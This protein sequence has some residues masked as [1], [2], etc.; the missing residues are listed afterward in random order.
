MK[1]Y[2]IFILLLVAGVALV[3]CD[4]GKDQNNAENSQENA[5]TTPQD[6]T[7][8][9]PYTYLRVEDLKQLQLISIADAEAILT[10][11][12]YKGGWQTYKDP[13][14][15]EKEDYLYTSVDNRDTIFLFTDPTFGVYFVHYK[16]SKGVVPSEAKAWLTHIPENYP[17]QEKA[18]Q[19]SGLSDIPFSAAHLM[20][21]TEDVHIQC[22]TYDEYLK[23][24]NNLSSG[25]VVDVRWGSYLVPSDWPTGY[26]GGV[27]MDYTYKN[28][29]DAAELVIGFRYHE[30]V[31][32]SGP[33]MPGDE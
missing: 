33:V 7:E 24:L 14:G 9:N 19:I 28:N 20:G 17:L 10:K 31:D 2:F 32:E 21:P 8:T 11:M 29:R 30:H 15:H 25:M 13:D 22:S 27:S 5:Q 1:K 6:S 26:Y 23:N 4:K 16:A 3:S 18:K 12:G